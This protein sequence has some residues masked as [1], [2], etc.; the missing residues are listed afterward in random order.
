MKCFSRIYKDKTLTDSLVLLL[1]LYRTD[2]N[3]KVGDDIRN[4]SP[5]E[6]IICE[7]SLKEELKTFFY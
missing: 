4:N 6:K 1:N 3:V 7:T 2:F 5:S